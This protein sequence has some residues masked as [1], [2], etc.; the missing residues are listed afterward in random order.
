M[1]HGSCLEI[2]IHLVRLEML[3]KSADEGGWVLKDKEVFNLALLL[4]NLWQVVCGD[5]LWSQ[6]IKT[7]Y[8]YNMDLIGWIHV[9]APVRSWIS[10]FWRSLLLTKHWFLGNLCW[11][12]GSR[13]ILKIGLGIFSGF[14]GSHS[15]S[16]PLITFLHDMDIHFLK[17]I[18]VIYATSLH[19]SCWK[20]ARIL[21]LSEHLAH[22]WA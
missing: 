18:V 6:V 17:D 22:E 15:I 7:K 12:I 4:K 20:D 21:S 5:G 14:K 2:K 19:S 8:L 10:Q 9:A 16:F 13:S 3:T 1:N 11:N